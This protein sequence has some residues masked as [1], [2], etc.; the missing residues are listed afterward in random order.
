[1]HHGVRVLD[2]GRHVVHHLVVVF[3]AVAEVQQAVGVVHVGNF[4]LHAV[5]GVFLLLAARLGG[6][7]LLKL[8]DLGVVVVH[9]FYVAH[10]GLW[11]PSA[12]YSTEGREGYTFGVNQPF[13][14]PILGIR[15]VF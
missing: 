8:E 11:V 4:A 1:M 7:V 10:C 13:Q 3:L 15:I 6:A 12:S 2:H 5:I 9:D 14:Y